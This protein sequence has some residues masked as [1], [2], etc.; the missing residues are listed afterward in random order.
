M[1]NMFMVM[2]KNKFIKGIERLVNP[3][4]VGA[5]H[6]IQPFNKMLPKKVQETFIKASAKKS[7]HMGF[8]VEPYSFFLCYEITD[9]KKA[10]RILPDGFRLIKTS[11]FKDDKPKYYA[12]LSCFR[13]H[14]SAFWGT[15]AEF[16]IIAED[17]KTGLLSWII[18]DYDSDTI[19]YDSYNGLRSPNASAVHTTDYDGILTVDIDRA[20]AIRKISFAADLNNAKMKP[21]DQRL[22]LEG[23]LSVGY[24]KVLS[25]N[26]ADIFSLKFQP[27]EVS[28]AL[29][30]PK[31]NLDLKENSW[32]SNMIESSPSA[33]VCFPYA[34]HFM[35][36]SPGTSSYI[37]D[38]KDLE[39]AL[40]EID[41][42]TIEP[43]SAK[44]FHRA[45]VFNMIL[46]AIITTTL[47]ILLIIK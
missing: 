32:Y 37:A 9:T 8:V 30:I 25:K 47:I 19:S 27:D 42:K 33:L 6:F 31:E 46:S 16:Y 11:I 35:S 2:N 36:D 20:D 21:L 1:Y 39:K 5:L 15:R 22:W 26:K 43:V 24:G 34:Q 14:T 41:F 23:N 17:K 44:S 13:S 40:N 4:T 3:M 28:K 7:P 45:L 10:S 29:E 18:A 12:I 38:K